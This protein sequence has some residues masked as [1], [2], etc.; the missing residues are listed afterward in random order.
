MEIPWI[1]LCIAGKKAILLPEN[2]TSL[3]SLAILLSSAI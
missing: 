1:N 3:V 2:L